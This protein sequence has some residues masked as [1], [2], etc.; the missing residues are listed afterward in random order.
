MK[1]VIYGKLDELGRNMNFIFK[2][3][4]QKLLDKF[5]TSLTCGIEKSSTEH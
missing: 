5:V 3:T 2:E 1:S 4:D